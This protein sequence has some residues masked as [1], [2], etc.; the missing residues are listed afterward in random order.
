M[1]T[2][3]FDAPVQT[4]LTGPSRAVLTHVAR[5]RG[6]TAS[7]LVRVILT[8]WM[9]DNVHDA[10][11]RTAVQEFAKDAAEQAAR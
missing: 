4:F 11:L 3:K 10:D 1:T 5:E 2:S 7:A 8:E 9:R 6:L